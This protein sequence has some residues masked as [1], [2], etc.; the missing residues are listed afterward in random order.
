[1]KRSK[2]WQEAFKDIFGY[3]NNANVQFCVIRFREHKWINPSFKTIIYSNI[4]I[5]G[6]S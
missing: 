3:R 2:K 1:M 4:E 6:L 5:I